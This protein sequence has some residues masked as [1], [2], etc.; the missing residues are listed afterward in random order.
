MQH[1]PPN[2]DHIW[3]SYYVFFLFSLVYS[4]NRWFG[5]TLMFRTF[6][7]NGIFVTH[8]GRD[9]KL[10]IRFFDLDVW[11]QVSRWSWIPGRNCSNQFPDNTNTLS[12]LHIVNTNHH[13]LSKEENVQVTY[14]K[15]EWIVQSFQGK[16]SSNNRTD[17]RLPTTLDSQKP[18]T[19]LCYIIFAP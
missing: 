14:G 2:D 17:A 19:L 7:M 10:P 15:A 9:S 18:P 13:S 4:Y 11:L 16:G 5:M 8:S 3:H 6:L 1:S 12:Y